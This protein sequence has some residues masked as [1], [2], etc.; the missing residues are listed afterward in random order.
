VAVR[1]IAVRRKLKL[2]EYGLFDASSGDLI[3]SA[4]EEEVYARLGM[5]WVPPP[6]RENTGEVRA[7]LRGELPELVQA[8]DVRGDLH[9]HTNLTDGVGTLEE[10]V[11]TARGRGYEYFAVTDHAPNLFMQRM[12]LERC[13]SNATSSAD[14]RADWPA[15]A[16]RP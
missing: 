9:T 14:S 11:T 4:T 1:E 13:L 8:G 2:S 7:A 3:V 15:T 6:L 10:M 5:A 12:T 16:A